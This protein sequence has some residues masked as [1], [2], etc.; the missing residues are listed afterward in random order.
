[1]FLR[2][3]EGRGGGE[4]LFFVDDRF[5]DMM[6]GREEGIHARNLQTTRSSQVHKTE[7]LK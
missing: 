7:T 6:M 3:G 2:G 1:L 5:S 4:F